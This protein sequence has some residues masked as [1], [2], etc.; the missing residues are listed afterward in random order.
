MQKLL[1]IL[2]LVLQFSFVF[3]SEAC[4]TFLVS[5][6]Y[7]P[8]GRPLL[9]KHRDTG[10]PNNAV[11]KFSDGKYKYVGM[12]NATDS[13]NKE[14]W[15]GYNE[16]GF[17]IINSAAYNNN[18]GDNTKFMDQEG[19]IMKKALQYCATL[20]DFEN[21]IDSLP[22]PLGVDANFGVV[23]ALGGAAY[24][25]T[26]N[27][28]Y[29][30]A[31]ANDPLQAPS[32]FLVRTNH[33]FSG[34]TDEGFGYIRYETAYKVLSEAA[35]SNKME[36]QY[37]LNH[38]S[39]NLTHSLT[40][41]N[42]DAKLVDSAETNDFRFFID[43][44]PRNSSAS[45]VL[46]VGAKKPEE[47]ANTMMW[48]ITGFQLATL[49]VPVWLDENTELP[50]VVTLN[51]NGHAPICD[52]ALQLKAKCFPIERGSG[53][54]YINFSVVMNK[55]GNGFLQLIK[56]AEDIIFKKKSVPELS[57]EKLSRKNIQLFYNWID[58]YVD[59]FYSENFGI[60]VL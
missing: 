60:Q 51:K 22:K 5:G 23:D 26:G 37:L 38:I 14:V 13:W 6:K 34:G 7:T 3:N 17:G 11:V 42:L 9:Y 16:T 39:R 45:T 41:E 57:G 21:L 35:A 50:R 1:F 4:T 52:A 58:G 55:K 36:P 46:I 8:D 40:N 54:K 24:Y 48:T 27:F 28:K 2:V 20:N 44:I 33:S 25:E 49:A 59:T 56:P 12:V 29:V 19:V 43:Y 30:K 10:E 31:D 32:G 15:G 47:A 53:D 18:I